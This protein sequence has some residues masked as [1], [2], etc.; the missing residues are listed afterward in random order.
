V[1]VRTARLA[2]VEVN[3]LGTITIATVPAGETWILKSL[4]VNNQ[5]GV[6]STVIVLVNRPTPAVPVRLYSESVAQGATR[7]WEGWLVLQPGD[8]VKVN[9]SAVSVFVWASGTRLIGLA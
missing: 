6:A 1:S 4:L 8:E 7:T 3:A 2:A 5:S 9:A